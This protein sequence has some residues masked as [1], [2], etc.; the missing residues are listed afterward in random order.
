VTVTKTTTDVAPSPGV[1][2]PSWSWTFDD[3]IHA[4]ATGRDTVARL[5]GWN[6]RHQGLSVDF[7]APWLHP[8]GYKSCWLQ[9]PELVSADLVGFGV[10]ASE[11]VEQRLGARS[12][13]TPSMEGSSPRI[14]TSTT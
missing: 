11:S 1:T 12:G 5:D 4:N 6:R 3:Q 13:A 8:R 10:N 9:V 7:S 2:I 14:T